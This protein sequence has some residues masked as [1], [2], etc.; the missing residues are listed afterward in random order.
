MFKWL[1]ALFIAVFV[2]GLTQPRLAEWLRLGRLPGDVR[3]RLRSREVVFP[4]ASSLLLSF[5]LTAAVR[6]L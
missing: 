6:L 5:L 2:F 3:L 1:L 4:F